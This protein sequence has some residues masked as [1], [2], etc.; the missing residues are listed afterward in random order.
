MMAV[1]ICY[2]H[3]IVIT[4]LTKDSTPLV[5]SK[6]LRLAAHSLAAQFDS[7]LIDLA[8]RY[9]RGMRHCRLTRSVKIERVQM[10]GEFWN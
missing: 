7:G 5:C 10:V 3:I 2:K 6:R 9:S 4:I 1:T 8:Q